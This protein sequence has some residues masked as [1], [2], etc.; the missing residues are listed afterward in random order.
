MLLKNRL[1]NLLGLNMR[2]VLRKLT[3]KVFL[4][5]VTIG[6]VESLLNV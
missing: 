1:H 5:A 6:S 2:Q 3:M 4:H